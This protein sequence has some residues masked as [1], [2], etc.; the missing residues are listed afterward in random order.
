MGSEE[1]E[2]L[3]LRV[4]WT[5]RTSFPQVKSTQKRF[6]TST[7]FPM[8]W[9]S[10]L[11]LICPRWRGGG[12]AGSCCKAVSC[13]CQERLHEVSGTEPSPALNAGGRFWGG[14]RE[15]DAKEVPSNWRV[16]TSWLNNC[17]NYITFKNFFLCWRTLLSILE[18]KPWA[19]AAILWNSTKQDLHR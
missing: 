16:T 9:M 18:R 4:M 7:T 2:L 6:S 8:I 13:L 15:G 10:T 12:G 11:I 1:E 14:G 3:Y 17:R 19:L 5:P